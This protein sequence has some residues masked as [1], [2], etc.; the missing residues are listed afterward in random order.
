MMFCSKYSPKKTAEVI[1]NKDAVEK[2]RRWALEWDR[3]KAQKPL[4]LWG[5]TGAGKTSLAHAIALELGWDALELNSSQARNSDA[6]GRLGMASEGQRTIFGGMRMILIDDVDELGDGDF[7]G[8]SA[9]ARLLSSARNPIVLTARDRYDRKIAPLRDHCEKIEF[10]KVNPAS[11]ASLLSKIAKAEKLEIADADIAKIAEGAGGDVRAAINDL[12]GRSH[13]SVREREKNV[14]EVVRAILKTQKYKE[15][16]QAAFDAGVDH[17]TLKLWIAENIPAEYEKPD[18]IAGAFESLSRAD[19]FDGRI[20]KRQYWGFL[21][22]SSDLMSAGVSVA[23]KEP[24]RKFTAYAYPSYMRAMGTTKGGRAK[25]K[26]TLLKIAK[27]AHCSGK[28]AG[29]YLPLLKMLVEKDAAGT[30][31]LIGLEA[32]EAAYIAGVP[33]EKMEKKLAK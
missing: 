5:S 30:A 17:D 1:G 10:K 23:K 13:S 3:G 19:V 22:Y 28:E 6:I 27:F 33:E 9:I 31:S 16:R 4:L 2:V 24:Y 15:A 26:A 11:I 8:G 25:R 12:Q 20:R 21:R 14:F 7:G 18:E 32:A 29:C